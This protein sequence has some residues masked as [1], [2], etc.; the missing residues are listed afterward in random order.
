MKQP[1]GFETH[2]K[3]DFVVK[4]RHSIYGTPQAHLEANKKLHAVLRESGLSPLKSDSQVWW[5]RSSEG[6]V[7]TGWHVDDA[8]ACFSSNAL[9][10]KIE[11]IW[12]KHFEI[13]K[14]TDPTSYLGLNIVRDRRNRTVEIRQDNNVND[15]IVATGMEKANPVTTPMLKSPSQL[16]RAKSELLDDKGQTE[17]MQ[18]IGQL[19]W[20]VNTRYDAAQAIGSL[21]RSTK[22]ATVDDLRAVKHLARY[23]RYRPKAGIRITATSHPELTFWMRCDASFLDQNY[24]KSTLGYE[25]HLGTPEDHGGVLKARSMRSRLPP[26]STMEAE[27]DASMQASNVVIWTRNWLNELGITQTAPTIIENDNQALVTVIGKD[28]EHYGRTKH[29]ALRIHVL[30]DL[31]QRMIIHVTHIPGKF[32]SADALTKPLGRETHD[33]FFRINQGHITITFNSEEAHD[34]FSGSTRGT[35]RSHMLDF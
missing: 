4:L 20:L 2:N 8:Q 32:N 3:L 21:S 16:D 13:K 25:I 35:S 26:H 33:Y 19:I 30:Q 34:D 23:F 1:P 9:M 28:G 31:Q 17:Y 10:E 29:W 18:F 11:G 5:S 12:R 27:S 7:I 14:E 24:S 6:L 22:K 15:F